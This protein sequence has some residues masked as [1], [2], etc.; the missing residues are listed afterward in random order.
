MRIRPYRWYIV[1]AITFI[2]WTALVFY[3]LE[4]AVR[5]AQPR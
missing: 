1:G 4:T 3:A 2:A 5:L